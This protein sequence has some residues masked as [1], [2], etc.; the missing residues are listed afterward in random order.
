MYG[1]PNIWGSQP[2][3]ARD[4]LRDNKQRKEAA[5]E[6]EAWDHHLRSTQDVIGHFDGSVL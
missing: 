1:V 6:E 3:V 5:K 4:R 2:Y